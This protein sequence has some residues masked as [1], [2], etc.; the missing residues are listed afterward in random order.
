[1]FSR[2]FILDRLKCMHRIPVLLSCHLFS[3][4]FS[5][6]V[7][8]I[9]FLECP[10]AHFVTGSCQEIRPLPIA[11]QSSALISARNT[12]RTL[13]TRTRATPS[14]YEKKR[15][16]RQLQRFP[17]RAEGRGNDSLAH[18]YAR[19]NNSARLD[20][21]CCLPAMSVPTLYAARGARLVHMMGGLY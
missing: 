18:N 16:S 17:F 12:T 9:V 6:L 15:V 8:G 11:C 21:V 4:A 20:Y 19:F 5:A 1:M 2:C 10:T 7:P 13:R 3:G 14:A